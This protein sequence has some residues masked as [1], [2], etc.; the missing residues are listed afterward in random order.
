MPKMNVESFN[1]DHRTVAAPFIRVADVKRLPHGDVLTKYDIRFTQPNIAHLETPAIHSIEHSFAELARNHSDHVVDFSP[2]GC[3]TGFY[4]ILASEPDVPGVCTLVEETF[5][6]MLELS[7][8]PAANEVQ[9]GWGAHHSLEGMKSAV[10]EMLAHRSEW[11]TVS[12]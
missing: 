4:L 2:M 1:L 9:C 11:E 3:Q 5:T 10:G 7:Q 12:R 6:D 8:V